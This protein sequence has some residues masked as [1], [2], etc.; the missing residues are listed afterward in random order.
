MEKVYD[1][2]KD[3]KMNRSSRWILV[4]VIVA[5][6]GL[7]STVAIAQNGGILGF[8]K[9]VILNLNQTIPIVADVVIL[10]NNGQ[11]ITA[12]VP[13]TIELSMQ[14]SISGV[15]SNSVTIKE[16]EPKAVI[17]TPEPVARIFE[18]GSDVVEVG[19]FSWRVIEA[20]NIGENYSSGSI[21]NYTTRGSF[22]L[23]V[24]KE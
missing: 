17:S 2:V 18:S 6:I 20:E 22:L 4:V 24:L 19:G 11:P 21:K 13:L 23:G 1:K 9:P 14:V 12:T 8:A 7:F 3:R 15:I 10:G 16:N 5:L